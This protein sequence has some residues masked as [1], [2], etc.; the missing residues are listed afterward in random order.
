MFVTQSKSSPGQILIADSLAEA[1]TLAKPEEYQDL[2]GFYQKVAVTDQEELVL[3]ASPGGAPAQT[4]KG[5]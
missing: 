2:R 5:N 3:T 4:G 1:Y